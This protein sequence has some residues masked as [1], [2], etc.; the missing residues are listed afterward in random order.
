MNESELEARRKH[1]PWIGV[2]G[3]LFLFF[4]ILSGA[5]AGLLAWLKVRPRLGE[6]P[7]LAGASLGVL[8]M[9]IGAA[10]GLGGGILISKRV[11][12]IRR[13]DPRHEPGPK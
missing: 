4:F 6:L 3:C 9:Y 10:I 5:G 11:L 2:V 7:A 13:V 1:E 8:A 12:R